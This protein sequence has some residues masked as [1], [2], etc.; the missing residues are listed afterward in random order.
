[1]IRNSHSEVS[2]YS[3]IRSPP[4]SF[5]RDVQDSDIPESDIRGKI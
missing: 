4:S 5:D 1:M 2:V 3:S